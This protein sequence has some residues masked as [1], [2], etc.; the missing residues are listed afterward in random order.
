MT[1]S[2]ALNDLTLSKELDRKA[3]AK[4]LGCGFYSNYLLNV[5]STL[6]GLGSQQRLLQTQQ[7]MQQMQQMMQTMAAI[8]KMTSYTAML[9]I[10]NIR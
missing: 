6:G 5:T 1:N 7:Q 9:S 8:A 3:L 10:R 4:V 2:L